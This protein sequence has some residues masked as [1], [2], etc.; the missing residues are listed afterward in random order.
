MNPKCQTR[1]SFDTYAI[2]SAD[3]TELFLMPINRAVSFDHLVGGNEQFVWHGK[4]ERSGGL[5]IDDQ[6]E[7]AR[8]HYRQIGR[9]GALEN[10]A[11][12]YAD[13]TTGIRQ[14]RSVA[15]QRAGFDILASRIYRRHPVDRRQEH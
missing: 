3:L 1:T 14:T 7:F 4:A 15:H 8:L 6:L 5:V 11:G 10:A 12:I 13:L 2:R 9:L